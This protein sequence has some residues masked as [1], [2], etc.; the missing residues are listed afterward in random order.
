MPESWQAKRWIL[1]HDNA[2]AHISLLV[3]DF[4]TKTETTVTPQPPYSLGIAPAEFFVFPKL[5]YTFK[6]RRFDTTE[7]I[8]KYAEGPEVEQKQSTTNDSVLIMLGEEDTAL[9]DL[10]IEID[11]K[12][13][14]ST[15]AVRN[16]LVSGYT[17]H[18]EC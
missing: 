14:K 9:N 18:F 3:G 1:H 13:E 6:R 11:N 15:I 4:L 16:K 12:Q 7:E 5:K 17:K 2:L 10:I 8:K